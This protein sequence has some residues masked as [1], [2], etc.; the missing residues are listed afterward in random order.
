V[1]RVALSAKNPTGSHDAT[2][3]ANGRYG[4][5]IAWALVGLGSMFAIWLGPDGFVRGLRW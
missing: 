4:R 2:A 1:R 5:A 3:F